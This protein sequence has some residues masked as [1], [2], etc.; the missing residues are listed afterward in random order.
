MD[1][2]ADPDQDLVEMPAV[3]GPRAL[4]A[5]PLCLGPAEFERPPAHRLVGHSDP[6]LGKQFLDVAIAK[7]E[8]EI[9]PLCVLGDLRREAMAGIR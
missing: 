3:C 7:R 9:K 6:A 4:L 8:A 1:P 5:D 2:A